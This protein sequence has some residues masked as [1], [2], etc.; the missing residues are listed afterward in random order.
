MER[1]HSYD[2][3]PVGRARLQPAQRRQTLAL[4]G[5]LGSAARVSAACTAN[6]RP[7][8][9]ATGA[10]ATFS[11]GTASWYGPKFNG[12]RTAS[13]ERYDMRELTAAPPALPFGTLVQ[14][15]NVE[16]GRQ[17][18]VRINDRGP[19]GHRRIIDLSYAAARQLAMIG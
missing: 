1:D 9:P 14:V 2:P 3:A 19:F 17:V 5:L 4:A 7:A 12:R 15:T 18:V 11:H 10:G 8:T 13:G 16:N 6:H